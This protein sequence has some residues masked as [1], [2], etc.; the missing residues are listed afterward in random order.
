MGDR[1]RR[2]HRAPCALGLGRRAA[3]GEGLA[4]PPL[5]RW[6]RLRRPQKVEGREAAEIGLA[7]ECV[8]PDALMPRALELAGHI[9]ARPP[10]T[11]RMIKS[12]FRQS[13]GS[14]LHDFLDN[15]AALQAICHTTDDHMEAVTSILEKR[16]P[17]FRG[18]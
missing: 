3:L 4:R 15:C 18:K 7:L 6:H 2:G 9:A 8:E 1:T 13:L 16:E 12:L 17:A 5:R 10:I 14:N 11:T